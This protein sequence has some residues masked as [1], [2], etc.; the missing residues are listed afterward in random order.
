MI[1]YE[2]YFLRIETSSSTESH[3]RQDEEIY[4]GS[5]H[6][7][8]F[9]CDR[10]CTRREF[11]FRSQSSKEGRKNCEKSR[12]QTSEKGLQGGGRKTS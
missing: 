1:N 11:Q 4:L 9:D 6:D 10:L 12:L 2:K 3:L 8:L 7:H 5:T